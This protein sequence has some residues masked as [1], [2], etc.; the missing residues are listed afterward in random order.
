METKNIREP[1]TENE[2]IQLN[3]LYNIDMLDIMEIS[4]INNRPP[5]GIIK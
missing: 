2:D 5:G 4:K 3:Q 1:W